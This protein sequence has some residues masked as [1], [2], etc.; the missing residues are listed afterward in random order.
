MG[1]AKPEKVFFDLVA[2]E[3]PDFVPSEAIV[4]GDSLSSDILGGINAGL[5]TCWYNPNSKSAPEDMKITRV[6][7]SFDDIYDFVTDGE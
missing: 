7:K 1:C 2:K 3:I 5:D 6:A 4:I